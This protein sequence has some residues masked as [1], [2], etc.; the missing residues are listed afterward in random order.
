M[1]SEVGFDKGS[2]YTTTI[3]INDI[4]DIYGFK[5]TLGGLGNWQPENLQIKNIRNIIFIIS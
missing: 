2:S 5:L 4:G 3:N 1:F